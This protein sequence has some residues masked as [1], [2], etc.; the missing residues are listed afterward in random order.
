VFNEHP[1]VFRT[2]LVGVGEHGRQV[3]VLCVE[4]EPGRRFTQETVDGLR[5]LARGTRY[6]GLV[7]HFLPHPGFPTDARHNSKIRREELRSWAAERIPAKGS[8]R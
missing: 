5:A 6:E 2:A 4:M 8:G 3:P 1:D 7:R